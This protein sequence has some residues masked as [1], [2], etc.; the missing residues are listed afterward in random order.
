MCSNQFQSVVLSPFVSFRVSLVKEP[1]TNGG[2]GATRLIEIDQLS[3][4]NFC[5]G[6][7]MCCC[8]CCL[9]RLCS[10]MCCLCFSA[11]FVVCAVCTFPMYVQSMY[12]DHLCHLCHLC[13]H[14]LNLCHFMLF[15]LFVS[16]FVPFVLFVPAHFEMCLRILVPAQTWALYQ[17]SPAVLQVATCLSHFWFL[18]DKLYQTCMSCCDILVTWRCLLSQCEN[19]LIIPHSCSTYVERN[20]TE[21]G[22]MNTRARK[23]SRPLGWEQKRKR[24][25]TQKG[26]RTSLLIETS[27]QITK[28]KNQE[29]ELDAQKNRPVHNYW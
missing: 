19:S 3:R 12:V 5:A 7:K 23:S 24:C 20:N 28:T 25:G 2:K 9:C 26:H 15:A 21:S 17:F 4:A 14:I 10:N 16:R 11:I 22:V 1:R 29:R 13:R 6:T 27:C 18:S 8:L